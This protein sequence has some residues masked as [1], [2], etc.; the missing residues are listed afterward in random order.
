MKLVLHEPEIPPN[1]GNI[2]RLCAAFDIELHLIEPLGFSLDNRYLKR[3]GLD[4]WP[5]VRLK[6]WPCWDAFQNQ[7]KNHE[8][9][10][11]A[12]SHGSILLQNF[13]FMPDDAIIM[14]SETRGLPADVL[15][16][17]CHRVR[18]PSI[19]MENGGVRC[20]NL[21]TAAGIFLF[22][23][24]NNCGLLAALD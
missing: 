16:L 3:A 9:L 21:S 13:S 23:A 20:L 5:H 18:I 6:V 2:V 8:R 14:G 11:M 4:Y 15:E 10:V 7:L 22:T 24:M 12:T 1:T 19:S 17:S